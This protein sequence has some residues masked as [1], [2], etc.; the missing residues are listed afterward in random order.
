MD[1]NSDN[2]GQNVFFFF[3]EI[4]KPCVGKKSIFHRK[5]PLVVSLSA[6]LYFE[7]NVTCAT[8]AKFH[9]KDTSGVMPTVT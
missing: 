2:R 5:K 7:W 8:K 9:S 6:F 3:T 4:S 1:F